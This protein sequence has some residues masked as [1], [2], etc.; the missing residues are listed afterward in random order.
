MTV[1]R[2]CKTVR[3]VLV[4]VNTNTNHLSQTC[5]FSESWRDL[6]VA[7]QGDDPP[8]SLGV[9]TLCDIVQPQPQ[10]VLLAEEG[11]VQVLHGGRLSGRIQLSLLSRQ[12]HLKQR[13]S[14][15]QVLPGGHLC[16]RE[17]LQVRSEILRGKVR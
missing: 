12:E 1:A 3:P 17:Q 8:L 7:G 6:S 2:L 14:A 5:L 13:N 10:H 15:L 9:E 16:Q 4:L 11:S